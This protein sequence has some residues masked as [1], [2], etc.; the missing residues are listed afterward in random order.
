MSDVLTDR[1]ATTKLMERKI[2]VIN[3]EPVTIKHYLVPFNT[4]KKNKEKV[5]IQFIRLKLPCACFGQQIYN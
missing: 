3:T 5:E 1:P 2:V 4:E